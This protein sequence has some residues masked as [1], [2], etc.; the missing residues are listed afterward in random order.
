MDDVVKEKGPVPPLYKR[1]DVEVVEDL[2]E[3]TTK[4]LKEMEKKQD[5]L[6]ATA[7][8]VLLV[9]DLQAKRDKLDKAGMDLAMKGVKNFEGK[10]KKANKGAK[11]KKTK[12]TA[13]ASTSSTASA[14]S[15]EPKKEKSTTTVPSKSSTAEPEPPA[16]R[17][18]ELPGGGSYVQFG[19]GDGDTPSEAE[20]EEIL[21]KF[22]QS[23]QGQGQAG[24]KE[25]APEHDEL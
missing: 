21:K 2:Y 3:S 22:E 23:Q 18:V 17:T 25:D 13:T 20:I 24:A 15:G 9:K 4:W 14:S 11:S 8:P 1:E 12:S 10:T 16:G 6:A 7:D 19:G 5:V